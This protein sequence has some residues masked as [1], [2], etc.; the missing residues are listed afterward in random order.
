MVLYPFLSA[1]VLGPAFLM[2]GWNWFCV[3]ATLAGLVTVLRYYEIRAFATLPLAIWNAAEL[4]IALNLILLEWR[5]TLT[6]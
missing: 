2:L 3:V 1:L 6:N 4:V 5:R